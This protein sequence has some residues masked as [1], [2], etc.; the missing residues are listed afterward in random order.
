M[1]LHSGTVGLNRTY[2]TA[3]TGRGQTGMPWPATHQA[4]ESASPGRVAE[5]GPR[6]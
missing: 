2:L 5:A 6:G 3:R 4:R 1:G